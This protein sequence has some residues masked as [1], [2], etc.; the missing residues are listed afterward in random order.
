VTLL[1]G[2]KWLVLGS[3]HLPPPSAEFKNGGAISPLPHTFSWRGT[4][5]IK[6]SDN[7]YTVTKLGQAGQFQVSEDMAPI[8]LPI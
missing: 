7:L 3:N 8:A 5:L 2:V 4:Y 6:H 1:P